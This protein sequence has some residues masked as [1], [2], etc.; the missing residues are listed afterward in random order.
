[1]RP[2]EPAELS[3]LLDGELSP[4]R[5]D[6]VRQALYPQLEREQV[7]GSDE[8]TSMRGYADAM[9]EVTLNEPNAPPMPAPRSA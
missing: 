5:A 1:M 2:V 7:V 9:P 3:A 6:Q 4:D 8:Y